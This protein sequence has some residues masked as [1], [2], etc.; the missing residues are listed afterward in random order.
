[1]QQQQTFGN[2]FLSRVFILLYGV[3]C[4]FA[5]LLTCAYAVGFIGNIFLPKSL[6]SNGQESLVTALL[7][8]VALLGIFALQHSVMARQQFKAWWTQLIPKPIERSTYVLCS[9]LALI[10]VFWQWRPIGITIWQF[11]NLVAQIIF[12][13]LFTLGWIIVL[14]SSFL[15]NHFDLFGLRQVYLYFEEKEYTPLKFETPAFYEYVRH[16]LY[17]GWLLVFWMTPM[18]T[19]SHLVFALVT[20]IYILVAIQLEEKDLVDIHGEKYKNYRRQVPMLI[21][22]IGKKS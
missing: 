6:D 7:I 17:V 5:F 21:P 10:L 19:V 12:Y 11:D 18:M 3:F 16:P 13:S 2:S 1:M 15:I 4:Y 8:D 22:F 9:S 14:V 20:T